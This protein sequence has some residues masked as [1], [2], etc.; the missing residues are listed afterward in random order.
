MLRAAPLLTF[1]CFAV[2]F[3]AAAGR[4]RANASCTS[5]TALDD[6]TGSPCVAGVCKCDAGFG[7]SKCGTLQLG[8]ARTAFTMNET[9]LWGSAPVQDATT[10]V[11]HA[12]TMVG[13]SQ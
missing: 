8:Q 3:G 2:A 11:Y 7:G 1:A 6:C 9:W 10:G 12:F 4:L 5:A 13:P